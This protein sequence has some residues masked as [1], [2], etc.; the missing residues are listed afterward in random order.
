MESQPPITVNLQNDGGYGAIAPEQWSRW[1][2]H[3]FAQLNP[4]L[5]PAPGYELSLRFTDDAA[6]HQLNAQYRAIDRP[7]DV[8]A[9]AALEQVAP[10]YPPDEPVDL[11]DVV[12]SVETAQRQATA[13]GH[14]LDREML[15]LVSHGVLHLL[16]WDHPTEAD[17]ERMLAQQEVLIRSLLDDRSDLESAAAD[18]PL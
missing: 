2:T 5:P 13:Q 14:G 3:W 9:F 15:W 1:L 12:I 16:G 10:W 17:L 8:L 18:S 6:I 4:E 11:G 7:T